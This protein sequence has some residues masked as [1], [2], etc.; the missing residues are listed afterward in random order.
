MTNN[1]TTHPLAKLLRERILI[2][3]GAMGTMIQRHNLDEKD[4]RGARFKSWATDL[5]GNN[6]LLSLTRPDIIAGIHTLYLEAGADIIETNTFNANAISMADYHMENLAHELNLASAT[7]ARAAADAVTRKNPSRPRFV[8]GSIGPTNRTASIS[9]DVNDPGYRAVDFDRLADAYTAQIKGL[10]EGG[11]DFLLIETI[12]DTLNA[13]AAIHAALSYNAAAAKAL[14]IMISGTITDASGRT[15]SGQTAEAFWISVQH[16]RPLAVGFNCALGAKDMTPHLEILAKNAGTFVSAYPNAG[17]PDQFGQY[18]QTPDQMAALVKEMADNGLVNILGGCCGSTPDH[19]RAIAHAVKSAAPRIIPAIKPRSSYS[20]LEP[21]TICDAAKLSDGTAPVASFINIGERTNVTGSKKFSKLIIDG[22]YDDALAVARQQ[23]DAGAQIIDINMDDAMIDSKSA[24]VKFLNLAMSEP[25]IARVPVMID[26]SRWDVLEAGLKCLQGKAIVNSISLKEGEIIFKA[27]AQKI[28]AYG[29]AAVVMAFDE[30]G[31]ADTRERKVAICRRAYGILLNEIG[32]PPEDIIFDPNIFAVATGIDAHNNYA[33]DFIEAV[34]EIKQTLPDCRTSGGVSNVS[35][36]F[37]GNDTIREAMHSVFLY[38]AIKAG[39]DMGIVNAGMLAVYEEIPRDLFSLVEN[40]ILNRQPDATEKLVAF[41]ETFKA[42]G[43]K[44]VE[45]Q[46]WRRAPLEE[47]LAHSLVKGLTD[48]IEVDIAEALQKY[49]RALSIIEGPLMK[50]MNHVGDLFGEGKMFLPQVVK[51]ARVMKKAVA[52]LQPAIEQSKD[53][54]AT[55]S[56]RMLLATV[57]GDVHDIGK[58]IAGVVLACN[59]FEIIDLGVMVST[60]TI[61]AKAKELKADI[62]GLSGLITPS[63]DEMVKI[64]GAMEKEGFTIPLALGGATTSE[65]HTAVKIAPCYR[66][67][68]VHMKDASKSVTACRNLMDQKTRGAFLAAHTSRQEELREAFA[69][70]RA[71]WDLVPLAEA[72]AHKMSNNW[73][74]VPITTPSFLGVKHFKNVDIQEVCA[75]IDWSFFFYAWGFKGRYP[76]ILK[77]TAMGVEAANLFADAQAM[78]EEIIVKKLLTCQAVIGLFPANSA[79]DDIDVYMDETRTTKATSFFT[80][81]QQVRKTCE[82]EPYTA[83]ADLVAPKDSGIKDYIGAFAVT[84][85]IGMDA[86][87]HA[88]DN[89]TYKVMLLKTLADRLAEAFTEVLHEK[90]RR[91]LW[92]YAPHEKLSLDD[93]L[94]ARYRGIRPAPGYAACPDHTEKAALFN[95]LRAETLTDIRLT[96]TFMMMPAAS[97]CGLYFAHPA[98]RYFPIGK[99]DNGQLED[100]ARRK[101]MPVAE[102]QKWLAPVLK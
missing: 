70:E 78:L 21:L 24:M 49:P 72:R 82:G 66:G 27:Q 18:T 63:L 87:I 81:R 89:D 15:L 39:L 98:A 30:N 57:K 48:F 51:S 54:A 34:R 67:P 73:A 4:Y 8:A 53:T 71:A 65:N 23:V 86:A 60:E 35:F 52:C 31:Q 25:D 96:E 76:A 58:N 79:G 2:I 92:G 22:K 50:G 100:Y 12:F 83:L 41:A 43:P 26:S 3:D 93:I 17:L 85:G 42:R 20:G 94:A 36:S 32:F 56:G 90:V 77:N 33:L 88:V 47:R 14:P 97:V 13:K 29:A 5:K 101:N 19:I 64:A 84:A 68:V 99:I 1:T 74:N 95:L 11:V 69:R 10:T 44:I 61:L 102:A 45:D 38:H 28:M 6:D 62:I 7:I 55:T 40:V 37:R 16:A 9:P 46:S 59:N 80:L 91:E 75:R